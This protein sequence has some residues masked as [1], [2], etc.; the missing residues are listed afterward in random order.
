MQPGVRALRPYTRQTTSFPGDLHVTPHH[1]TPA[2]PAL[3]VHRPV[4]RG[5]RGRD[6][7]LGPRGVLTHP[8]RR[9]GLA[10]ARAA[11][12]P[13]PAR[14]ALRG[15]HQPLRRRD[16]HRRHDVPEEARLGHRRG[17]R[18]AHLAQAGQPHD[19]AH[20]RGAAQRL[21]AGPPAARAGRQRHVGAPGAGPPQAG[22]LVR[23]PGERPLHRARPSRR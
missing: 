5:Q 22:A 21:H 8:P 9:H 6:R 16:P 14:T 13:A 23:R 3:L 4:R 7:S 18:R 15:R 19:R 11:E 10:G 12:P 17:R 2:R 1:R 20:R